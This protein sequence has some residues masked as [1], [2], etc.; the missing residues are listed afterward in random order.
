MRRET[1][2]LEEERGV[3]GEAPSGPTQLNIEH[4]KDGVLV[5]ILVVVVGGIVIFVILLFVLLLLLCCFV[6]LVLLFLLMC[7]SFLFVGS[8]QKRFLK[9]CQDKS[10]L[11]KLKIVL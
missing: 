3:G 2:K 4:S 7:L 5:G 6:C 9:S 1:T 10:M 8:C 11:L